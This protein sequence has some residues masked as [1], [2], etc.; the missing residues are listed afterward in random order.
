MT[1][2]SFRWQTGYEI[3]HHRTQHPQ[4]VQETPHLWVQPKVAVLNHAVF[5]VSGFI[6]YKLFVAPR[7]H[8]VWTK[9]AEKYL[10]L[11][12]SC[13]CGNSR[14]TAIIS[15]T[16]HNQLSSWFF[17]LFCKGQIW[18]WVQSKLNTQVEDS[19]SNSLT[20]ICWKK[21]LF[22]LPYSWHTANSPAS[23][24]LTKSRRDLGLVFSVAS[25]L[26]VRLT[27]GVSLK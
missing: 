1:V 14:A 18:K 7:D 6:T 11:V 2:L 13:G 25:F 8:S 9:N 5:P 23:S 16:V 12:V 17:H 26:I 3:S 19:R 15:P 4:M 27:C 10:D 20:P 24:R 22:P 21:W